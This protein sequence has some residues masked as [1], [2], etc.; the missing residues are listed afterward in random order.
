MEKDFIMIKEKIGEAAGQVWETLSNK[1]EVGIAQLPKMLNLK[2]EIAYQALG[3]LA[4]ENKIIY[5]TKA[6]KIY[7]S[8]SD[9]EQE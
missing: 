5:H 4:R 6:G 7:V 3:W 1:K 9:N 2:S 8:L